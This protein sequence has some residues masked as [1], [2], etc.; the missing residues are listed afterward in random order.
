MA[1]RAAR[2]MP[3]TLRTLSA[4]TKQIPLETTSQ[5]ASSTKASFSAP[6]EASFSS[7]AARH[8][9]ALQQARIDARQQTNSGECGTFQLAETSATAVHRSESAVTLP[10]G[11]IARVPRA[12]SSVP[13]GS[14]AF[15]MSATA[16]FRRDR[17][18]ARDLHGEPSG[19]TINPSL[20]TIPIATPHSEQA[21]GRVLLRGATVKQT[22]SASNS[23]SYG[24]LA[25]TSIVGAGYVYYNGLVIL[26]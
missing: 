6:Y 18:A 20:L 15:A 25:S 8:R 1:T 3:A 4:E 12:A 21:A 14:E 11:R 22:P 19:G 13:G 23:L 9:A 2:S 16:Q 10:G 26:P 5:F 17:M 24:I 7:A